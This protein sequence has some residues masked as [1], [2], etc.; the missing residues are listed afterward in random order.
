MGYVK[1]AEVSGK[2][3]SRDLLLPFPPSPD[4]NGNAMAARSWNRDN[5]GKEDGRSRAGRRTLGLCHRLES[6]MPTM[7]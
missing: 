3:P 7:N 4:W 1:A 6:L 5:F 2:G